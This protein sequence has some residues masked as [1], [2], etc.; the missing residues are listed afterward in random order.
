[1]KKI[2]INQLTF[3][4]NNQNQILKHL[5][6]TIEPGFHLL[7]GP[8]GCGKSTFL[9]ILAG[10]TSAQGKVDL[11]GQKVGMMFQ[12]VNEQF[13]MPTARQ[14]IIFTL[15]NLQVS[16]KDYPTRL[17]K[18]VNFTEIGPLLDQKLTELSGGQKQKV[19]LAV[20]IAMEVDIFLLDEPFASCDLASRKFLIKKLKTLS[21]TGKTVITSDH[22]LADYQSVC[23]SVLSFDHQ[24]VKKLPAKEVTQLL[25]KKSASYHFALP[26]K[27]PAC[28]TLKKL[29]ISQ[30]QLL[31]D[32]DQLLIPQGKKILITGPNGAG[33]TSFFKVLT[34]MLPYQGHLCYQKKEVKT[35]KTRSYLKNVGQV[36]Q[37]ADDQFLEVTLRDELAL[38]SK[39]ATAT[40][41]AKKITEALKLLNLDQKLDQVVYQLSGG[42]KKKLQILLMLISSPKVLLLDEPFSGLDQESIQ[43]VKQ[44]LAQFPD[45]TMLIIS[46]QLAGIA[47]FCDYH[48][49]FNQRQLTFSKEASE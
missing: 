36:F 6:L 13:T 29:Q 3:S 44:L 11:A 24:T 20:L 45:K 23:Q 4:Y 33:K 43:A 42:Q 2:T 37:D 9:R 31:L 14:E 18:A 40:F 38:S 7:I 41:S 30:K 25:T 28:F 21:Q 32:Q 1:M 12:N 8:T 48:L 17:K 16:K 22:N 46:H 10:L 47:D 39:H 15:E 27:M 5:K 19:A 34:K 26:Q 49:V 35:L